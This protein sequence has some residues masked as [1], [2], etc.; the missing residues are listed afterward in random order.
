MG[1]FIGA[2]FDRWQFSAGKFSGGLI[3]REQFSRGEFSGGAIFTEPCFLSYLNEPFRN[4]KF[5]YFFLIN[6]ICSCSIGF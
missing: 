3:F 4:F 2:I 6:E 1:I 5:S